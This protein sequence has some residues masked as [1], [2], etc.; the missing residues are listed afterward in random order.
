[1]N[2]THAFKVSLIFALAL[3]A[4]TTTYPCQANAAI[5]ARAID[6]LDAVASAEIYAINGATSADT[7]DDII[8]E[9]GKRIRQTYHIE[10]SE[11]RGYSHEQSSLKIAL[12]ELRDKIGEFPGLLAE[13]E[14]AIQTW[15]TQR[16]VQRV[17]R[18]DLSVNYMGGTGLETIYLF[19]PKMP[20]TEALAIRAFWYRE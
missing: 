10:G 15:A 4:A 6:S 17:E 19:I 1:M 16:D 8:S 3:V 7:P 2:W 5:V 13:E 18:L 9:I 20:A 12:A 14:I 11:I